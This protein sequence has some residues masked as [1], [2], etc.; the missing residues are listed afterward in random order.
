MKI[1]RESSWAA[2]RNLHDK[3]VQ[4][5]TDDFNNEEAARAFI[6]KGTT[7]NDQKIAFEWIARAWR[8][9]KGY[10]LDSIPSFLEDIQVYLNLGRLIEDPSSTPGTAQEDAQAERSPEPE[11]I[12]TKGHQRVCLEL[13]RQLMLGC[14][15][16]L[17]KWGNEIKAAELM[18]AITKSPLQSC[19]N[20]L[21]DH[22][23]TQKEH[24]EII[25]KFNSKLRALGI[26]ITL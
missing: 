26:E 23:I 22:D 6:A 8:E 3:A 5:L 24:E 12:D 4:T 1:I 10:G 11:P 16:D 19:K 2:L 18:S 9:C 14:G 21:S 17:K 20:I 7:L 25:H 15:A 13:L